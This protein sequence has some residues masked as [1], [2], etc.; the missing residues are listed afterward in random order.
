L[1]IEG[2]APLLVGLVG[3]ALFHN[4][5]LSGYGANR[6]LLSALDTAW[7][8]RSAAALGPSVLGGSGQAEAATA[9]SKVLNERERLYHISKHAVPPQQ[10]PKPGAVLL[11]VRDGWSIGGEPMRR[12][13]TESLARALPYEGDYAG[14]GGGS[15]MS[16][17]YEHKPQEVT[18]MISSSSSASASG[19]AASAA[20]PLPLTPER[21]E[22][23]DATEAGRLVLP[24]AAAAATG[25]A[26]GRRAAGNIS[27]HTGAAEAREG[28][29]GGVQ[30][31]Q[32]LSDDDDSRAMNFRMDLETNAIGARKNAK[33][34]KRQQFEESLL[35]DLAELL[36]VTTD[37]LQGLTIE[38]SDDDDDDDVPME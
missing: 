21:W 15:Y 7:L 14:Q 19:A 24:I 27:P 22:P 26:Q 16:S 34:G 12:Y 38:H 2:G 6:A 23:L 30:A 20:S 1:A 4:E 37:R 33:P 13:S 28:S 29:D 31:G 9:I 3:D 32:Q 36:G 35:A 25:G 10:P 8:V 5:W 11:G 18:M 17:V